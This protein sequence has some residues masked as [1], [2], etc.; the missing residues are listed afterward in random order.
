MIDKYLIT[1][2]VFS[3]GLI[4]GS[5]LNVL[6]YRVP[7][8]IMFRSSRSECPSCRK[9]ILWYENIPVVSYLFLKGKCSKC[10]TKISALYPVVELLTGFIALFI[11]R[12]LSNLSLLPY[13][14]LN[15][16]ILCV[17]VVLFFIDI[18]HKLLPDVLTG[19]LA[20]CFFFLGIM[21]YSWT[22]WL[23]GGL[24]GFLFPLAV[25]WF[26][27]KIKGQIGLGGGDIKLFGA[28]GLYLGPIGIIHNIFLSC[29][30]GSLYGVTLILSK[31]M[32]KTES[33]PFGPFIIIVAIFQI[34]FSDSY[35]R[36][37]SFILN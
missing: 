21:S 32:A 5:F 1:L 35:S 24:I 4:W 34:F 10:S 31:R 6:I 17:F 7:R 33:L 13:M 2:F 36:L 25:T 22:H 29:F 11:F 23:V 19:Y 8:G 30:V 18:E 20:L 37:I 28:L 26:F 27:Y 9:M 16:S 12:D 3:F 15:F 14:F